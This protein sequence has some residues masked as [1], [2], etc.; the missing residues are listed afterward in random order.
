MSTKQNG[1]SL[2]Y[3]ARAVPEQPAQAGDNTFTFIINTADIDRYETIVDPVGCVA[4]NF[5]KN[6]VVLWNHDSW[7]EPPIGKCID[8]QI[9][10]NAI[11]ATVEFHAE[12]E[13]SREVVALLA[14]GTLRG[15]S[16]GFRVLNR[17]WRSEEQ[18]EVYT[19]WELLEFSVVSIPANP[20]ALIVQNALVQ[21]VLMQRAL[22]TIRHSH[23]YTQRSMD[24]EKLKQAIT[25]IMSAVAQ[26]V[27]E[28]LTSMYEQ[29][30][31]T[32]QAVADACSSAVSAIYL[33]MLA[34]D[35]TAEPA[36]DPAATDSTQ[37]NSAPDAETRKGAAISKQT[38]SA[39]A[40]A[41]TDIE[42]AHKTAKR[43]STK[44]NA[45][46][47]SAA[48][49]VTDSVDATALRAQLALVKARLSALENRETAQEP[50]AEPQSDES[51]VDIDAL[52]AMFFN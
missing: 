22:N 50:Q 3:F 6:P 31:E 17:E 24:P 4:D 8:L 46:I 21:N 10:P 43:A 41:L 27:T 25:E 2:K 9:A 29:T 18:I 47:A 38:K 39:I 5:L 13:R 36:T 40:D 20:N 16:V 14:N 33:D 19:K 1:Q 30:P 45:L 23:T 7:G 49:E 37:N 11:T 51:V 26:L 34:A 35:A 44:L 15:V 32:A 52:K 12:T 42:E 48:D 28:H